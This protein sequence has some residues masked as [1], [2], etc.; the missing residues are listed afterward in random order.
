MNPQALE[1]G[2]P[3]GT[4][5]VDAELLAAAR[6]QVRRLTGLKGVAVGA[7]RPMAPPPWHLG[8]LSMGWVR[9]GLASAAEAACA[10]AAT[11]D[12][13]LAQRPWAISDGGALQLPADAPQ[14][15]GELLMRAAAEPAPAG[16]V[17]VRSNGRED[18]I[19]YAA[20]LARA[21]RIGAGLRAQGLQPGMPVVLQLP[22]HDDFLAVFWACVLTGVVPVPVGVPPTFTEAHGALRRLADAIDLLDSPVL[23]GDA[24]VLQGLQQAAAVLPLKAHRALSL[25]ALQDHAPMADVHAGEPD[26]VALMMLTSGSTGRPKGVPQPH[27]NLLA[28]TFGSQQMHG[29]PHGMVTLNWM[30]LDHVAGLIYFHLRDVYLAARQIH[31][32][33]DD[34]LRD[35]LSWLDLMDRHRVAVSFAPNFAFGLV[36]GQAQA[37]ARRPWQLGCVRRI[38]NGGEAIVAAPARRF[39]QLLAPHGLRPDA[40]MPAWGM[41]EVSSGVTYDDGFRLDTTTDADSHVRVGRPIPGV[42]LRIVDEAGQ[43]LREGQTGQLQAA[44]STVFGG[45]FGSGHLRAQAFTDDGWFRTGDLACL[46]DGRLTITGREKDEIIINGANHAGPAIEACVEEVPGVLASFAAA[47]AVADARAGGAEGL[48][49]FLVPQAADDASLAA[50][51]RAV[52]RQVVQRFG[53]SPAVLVP[54]ER[55]Q[56]PKTSIGKIQRG[57]LKKALAR[58]DFEAELRRA[59][60]LEDNE[61]TLPRWL[62]RTVWQPAP[63][64]EVGGAGATGQGT[65]LVMAERDDPL[66]Q[67]LLEAAPGSLL[68]GQPPGGPD[69]LPAALQRAA[70]HAAEGGAPPQGLVWLLPPAAGGAASDGERCVGLALWLRA[71]MPALA[72][73]GVPTRLALVTRQALPLEAG[74]SADPAAASLGAWVHTLAQEQAGCLAWHVDVDAQQPQRVARGLLADMQGAGQAGPASREVAWRGGLRHRPRLA[75]VWQAPGPTV[76]PLRSGGCYVVTGGLGGIGVLLAD[77]LATRWQAQVLLLCRSGLPADDAADTAAQARLAAWRQLSAHHGPRIR[78]AVAD[79]GDAAALRTQLDAAAAHW[80]QPADAVF[81][82]AG[83][84]HEAALADEEGTSLGRAFA[85][86]VGGLRALLAARSPDTALVCFS[87]AASGFAGAHVGAYAAANRAMEVLALTAPRVW[88][89]A[90]SSWRD[91]G[92]TRQHGAGEPLRAMGLR[93]M[94]VLQAL[95]SLELALR[96]PPGLLSIGLSAAAPAVAARTTGLRLQPSITVFCEADADAVP[97]AARALVPLIDAAG[98]PCPLALRLLPAWPRDAAGRVDQ[99][100]LLRLA[101]QTSGQRMPQGAVETRLAGLWQRV[102]GLQDLSLVSAEQS[103]FEL[104]GQSLLAGQLITAIDSAFGV[105]WTL[106]DVF[107]APTVAAQARRLA[108]AVPVQQAAARPLLPADPRQPLPLS[109]AQQRL[110]FLD[111]VHPR[112]PA[113]HIPASLRFAIAPDPERVRRALQQ[114]LDRHDSLR[115]CFPL[116]NGQA[117]QQVMPR[118]PAVLAVDTLAPAALDGWMQAEA[119]AGFDLATGPLLRARLALLAGPDSGA[120]LLLTLHHIV[121]DGESVKVLFRDWLAAYQADA[122]LP[123]PSWQYADF[124]AWQRAQ[125]EAGCHAADLHY[126]RGQLADRLDGFSLPTDRPRPLVQ[127]HAGATLR[128]PLPAAL[129]QRLLAFAAAQGVTPFVLLLAGFKALL[130]RYAQ[131]PDV[132]VGSVVANRDRAEFGSLIGFMV[133]VVV[134]RTRLDGDPGFADLLHRVQRSVLDAHAHH[135]LPFEALVDA[136]QPPRDSS[137]S[138]LFQIAFDLRD[139][140]ITRSPVPGITLDVM[141][142]DLGAVQYDLHLTLQQHAEGFTA[143]WQYSTG[144]FDAATIGRMARNFAVLLGAALEAPWQRL[145]TLALLHADERAALAAWNHRAAPFADGRCLH[146]LFEDRAALHPRHTALLMGDDSLDYATLETRS[147]AWAQRLQQAG[148]GP[149]VCV[150]LCLPRSMALVVVMLGILKAGGAF[151]PLDPSYPQERL[152]HM[153]ADAGIR[154]LVTD[155]DLAPRFAPAQAAGLQLLDVA[156]APPPAARPACAATA[157]SLAYVIY[158]SGSTGRPKGVLV[159]H[160]GWCNVAQA[161]QDVF[162]LGPGLRVLQF[163]SASFDACAFEVAMALASGGTLVLASREDLMP[164]PALAGLLRRQRVNVVTL[165]PTALAALP[166]P[167]PA[168]APAAATDYPDLHLVTVAGEACPLALVQQWAAPGRRFFNL[169]GPTEATIWSSVAECQAGDTQPPPI[170][171]P[172]P[173]TRLHVLDAQRQPLPWGMPGELWIGGVGVARGYHARPALDAERFVPDPWSPGPAAGERLYRSG[174]IVRLDAAGQLQFLGR[175]DHQ[176]K[177]RGFRIELGEIDALIREQPEVAEA[178]VTVHRQPDGEPS[179]AAYVSPRPGTAVDADR[180]RAALRER[181]PA[182]MVPAWIVVLAQFPLLANGKIDRHRLPDPQRHAARPAGEEGPRSALEQ[183]IAAAWAEV[184]QTGLPERH[185]N[186]FDI[187]GHSIKLA[188]VHARLKDALPPAQGQALTLVELFQH[189]TVAALAGFLATRGQG[190]GRA[191]PETAPV[192]PARPDAARLAALAQRQR[193][194]RGA[195]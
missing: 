133:N 81:H 119:R 10:A 152:D 88:S 53:I 117:C 35:P 157:A 87:S 77:W 179:L 128:S 126:W 94:S 99:P 156:Q 172:V 8:E 39:L 36:C 193:A 183:T 148:V 22:R 96:L 134:L 127:S 23:I 12:A 54:L 89:L 68:L 11:A 171:V 189:P 93:E 165:P 149:E 85:P 151:L 38:L 82:L 63:A 78:L 60:V 80:G 7:M 160:R 52:R 32:G 103:F 2:R 34:V 15:L 130:S 70:R 62:L 48:G 5:T 59:D 158:T 164:G 61:H 40:M 111:Q 150:G 44:G 56:V 142:P 137:R 170:G 33:V 190:P 14:L 138:P 177:L 49:L 90:W 104:G 1:T 114:L 132:V 73:A 120:V 118:Q 50:L 123:A 4:E 195:P 163:A 155:A 20:L 109:S 67:A 72:A 42:R 86:K 167:S 106:R 113:F 9:P 27:R 140:D 186:F 110:W 47:C 58:G 91:T 17:V 180:L 55:G 29:W 154:H 3:C 159:P 115:T 176:V 121:G 13:A 100:L 185:Q 169:Y 65:W 108:T 74:E 45:Y 21:L 147:N 131:Q 66:A 30:P 101:E 46:E 168:G 28:R 161:Q 97:E 136:L 18:E 145:S 76:G 25:A 92:L 181:L 31:V 173:N 95:A 153:V 135:A 37:L 84:Y 146:Q 192:R 187:G 51:L 19:S 174:D 184:L 166:A 122:P 191:A 16:L 139:T 144:L 24:A 162:G 98:Q 112:D 64:P 83:H 26:D 175:S 143:L 141:A 182:H 129:S 75:P 178:L 57:A 71:W 124:A 41:S 107:E 105:R 6:D 116:R 43:L 79:V 188:Q 125:A 102:L 69:G 194:A